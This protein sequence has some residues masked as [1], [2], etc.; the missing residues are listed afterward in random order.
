MRYLRILCSSADL[1]IK[2]RLEDFK[3]RF[4][5]GGTYGINMEG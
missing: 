4:C 2:R 1:K 5:N 3:W